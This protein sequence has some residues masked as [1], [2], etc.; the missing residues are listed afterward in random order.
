MKY[1][2]LFVI[3]PLLL[4]A[5]KVSTSLALTKAT[6]NPQGHQKVVVKIHRQDIDRV[7]RQVW[8]KGVTALREKALDETSSAPIRRPLDVAAVAKYGIGLAIHV[9]LLYAVL[10][11]IDALVDRGVVSSIPFA[12]SVVFFYACNLATSV[13]SPFARQSD[14]K[15]KSQKIKPTWTPPGFVFVIMWPIVV[16]GIRA[17]TASMIVRD[18][19]GS[20]A[21]LPIMLL[22]LHLTI[23]NWWNTVYVLTLCRFES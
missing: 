8:N 13:L 6:T 5:C 10:T 16:F 2:R 4:T 18:L 3:V 14:A 12:V 20:Y 21:N 9:S 7:V 22:M 23:A 15:N 19:G 1:H 17:V 11:G